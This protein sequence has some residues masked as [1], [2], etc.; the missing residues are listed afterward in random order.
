M[1][2]T[3]EQLEAMT[4]AELRVEYNSIAAHTFVGLEWYRE[5]LR[6]RRLGVQRLGTASRRDSRAC[7]GGVLLG[8][9]PARMTQNPA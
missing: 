2:P 8:S 9:E 7:A 3:I 1:A 4:D 5:E 6:Q